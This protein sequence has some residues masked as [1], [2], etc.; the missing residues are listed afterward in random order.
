[1]GKWGREGQAGC[2]WNDDAMMMYDIM[3][4]REVRDLVYLI[5][6]DERVR[7]VKSED[8]EIPGCLVCGGNARMLIPYIHFDD[9]YRDVGIVIL[10]K[11]L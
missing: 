6:Q 5:D 10:R 8:A 2:T 4:Y 3:V 7:V 11:D 9:C 1:M